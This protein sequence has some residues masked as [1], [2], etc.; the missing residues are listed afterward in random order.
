MQCATAGSQTVAPQPGSEGSAAAQRQLGPPACHGISPRTLPDPA[1]DARLRPLAA[2]WANRNVSGA[3]CGNG[4][5]HSQADSLHPPPAGPGARPVTQQG[6]R[7]HQRAGPTTREIRDNGASG[8]AAPGGGVMSGKEHREASGSLDQALRGSN[9]GTSRAGRM[10]IHGARL[11][12]SDMQYP[13]RRRGHY[14]LQRCLRRRDRDRCLHGRDRRRCPRDPRDRRLRSVLHRRAF[15]RRRQNR[16][17][18]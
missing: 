8:G 2:R 15:R 16:S 4:G 7:P 12:N 6:T 10:G 1:R 18:R 3:V 5:Q 13:I 14:L 9:R 17:A 11:R